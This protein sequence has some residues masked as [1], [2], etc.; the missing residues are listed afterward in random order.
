MIRSRNGPDGWN[1]R[2]RVL[3]DTW[4]GQSKLW[5]HHL[6]S[7]RGGKQL[8]SGGG[9]FGGLVRD[10]S[11][12]RGWGYTHWGMNGWSGITLRFICSYTK[13]SAYTVTQIVNV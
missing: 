3:M 8:R 4:L 9:I 13:S 6:S 12:W 5:V 2:G 10:V 11:E 7:W 1:S